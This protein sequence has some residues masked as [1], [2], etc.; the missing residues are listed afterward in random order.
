[1]KTFTFDFKDL[2]DNL[3]PYERS[4][5]TCNADLQIRVENKMDFGSDR[6]ESLVGKLKEIWYVHSKELRPYWRIALCVYHLRA[7]RHIDDGADFYLGSD[8][9]RSFKT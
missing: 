1:M 2:Y 7:M 4:N 9:E 5:P 6:F 8:S 3:K